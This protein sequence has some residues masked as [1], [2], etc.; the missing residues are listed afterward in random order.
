MRALEEALKS[1]VH[2][3]KSG[4][5]NAIFNTNNLI[6]WYSEHGLVEAAH[7]LFD[8]MSERNVYSWNAIINAYIKSRNLIKA[9][10]LFDSCPCK[11]H[12]TYNSMISGYARSGRY[13][14]EAIELLIQMQ[15]DDDAG[16]IDEFTLTTTLNMIAKLRVIDYGRQLH[17]FMVKSG[18]DL[19]SFALSSL[20]DMYSKCGNFLDCRRILS[21]VPL[22][23][24]V[25][26]N[27]LLAACFRE[28]KLEIARSMFFANPEVNDNV[29]WNTMISGYL[30]N[31][32]EKE[33]IELF[34]RMAELGFQWNEHTF[35][36]LLVCSTLK[37]LSI[38]KEVHSWVLK[39]GL[40]S[41]PFISSGLVDIYCKCGNMKYA[42]IVH[43]TFGIGNL[44]STTS[45]IVGYSAEGNMIKARRLFDSSTEKNPVMWTAIISGYT[46]LQ[47]CEDAFVLFHKFTVEEATIPDLLILISLLGACAL[48]A[49]MVPGKQIH[50]YIIRTGVKVD[51]KASCALID[52]YSKC[53]STIY[54]QRIFERMSQRDSVIYNVMIA[55]C[56]HHGNENEAT[57]LFE[58]MVEQG[59]QPDAVTFIALLS[60][61]RHRGLVEDGEKYFSVMTKDYGIPPEID[62]YSCMVDLYVRS[63]QLKKALTF[64]GKMD[65]K[66]DPVM[67]S[68]FL[69][70]CQGNGNIELAEIAE[71]TLLQIEGDNG[72]RYVQL[73]S[74]YASVGKWVEMGRIMNKMRR[75]EV[76]KLTGCSWLHIGSE[77]HIFTSG[78]LSHS[79]AKA[80][81]NTLGNL[82]HEIYD[83]DV[84]NKTRDI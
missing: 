70:A 66:P 49:S 43:E 55:C 8:E 50:A 82:S 23:D 13:E 14:N 64:I 65:I 52:M 15:C 25:V 41:N 38:G 33:A 45:M 75:K 40:L 22:V 20:I 34:K 29:S 32:L 39:G 36:S 1:H 3:I 48:R 9:R 42:E 35:A 11:D 73:A 83:A 79:D 59:L 69:N 60:A 19:S 47:K 71:S 28:G 81:Y 68:T 58:K 10:S 17:S 12:V 56:A 74:V 51:E 18:N 57:K 77:I 7:K 63:N 62:H 27:T 31:G 44:F 53:G 26:K 54:A 67:W 16:R 24:L 5:I 2:A 72:A 6:G 76:K 21:D 4:F 46:K 80:I 37:S 61:C 30:Q 84:S 78:D